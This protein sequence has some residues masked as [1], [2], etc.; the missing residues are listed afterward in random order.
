[1]LARGKSSQYFSTIRTFN[2]VT[3][4]IMLSMFLRRNKLRF[5][6]KEMKEEPT[7]SHLN[8]Q[9]HS[10]PHILTKHT[11]IYSRALDL[12]WII[13][14]IR[15]NR[16]V[17]HWNR[18]SHPLFISRLKDFL[19]FKINPHICYKLF[20]MSLISYSTIRRLL[21]HHR[22]PTQYHYQYLRYQSQ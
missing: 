20:Q 5:Q 13:Y 15:I 9:N 22:L 14:S 16:I 10:S 18:G 12:I 2:S 3:G 1:M 8:N 7:T 6:L 17:F 4:G 21:H 19:N 11:A